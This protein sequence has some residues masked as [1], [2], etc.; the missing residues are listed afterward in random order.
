MNLKSFVSTCVVA[1]ALNTNAQ[2][3]NNSGNVGVTP[4]I[5]K[6][7]NVDWSDDNATLSDSDFVKKTETNTDLKKSKWY[8]IKYLVSAELL[9]SL[10]NP[11]VFQWF[12]NNPWW[13][14][15][16]S[17]EYRL[18]NKTNFFI[19]SD[20][21]A[22]YDKNNQSSVDHFTDIWFKFNHKWVS[23]TWWLELDWY[24]KGTRDMNSFNVLWGLSYK[25]DKL[26]VSS[27]VF[28]PLFT[29]DGKCGD[30]VWLSNT[31]S[32]DVKKI[33]AILRA[34]TDCY[35]KWK[36]QFAVWVHYL[37][38]ENILFKVESMTNWNIQFSIACIFWN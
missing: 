5:L 28:K 16:G 22:T 25:Y 6:V 32:Y 31:V 33:K 37:L 24:P 2:S 30:G 19:S 4:E 14:I 38:W 23:L 10:Y 7:F 9:S 12:S 36:T 34:W 11:Q 13:H 26:D 1:F 27:I 35:E 15:T 20:L 8:N 18:N 3:Y 17:L 29:F 21:Y